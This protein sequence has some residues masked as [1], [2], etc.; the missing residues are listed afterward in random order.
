MT[1]E[2]LAK[3]QETGLPEGHAGT[4][5]RAELDDPGGPD[6]PGVP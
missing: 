3:L 6:Q 2:V 1:P 5:A 4:S